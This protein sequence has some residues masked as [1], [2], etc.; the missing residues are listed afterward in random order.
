M[1]DVKM[2]RGI[3]TGILTETRVEVPVGG[4]KLGY[5]WVTKL[6]LMN[7]DKTCWLVSNWWDL[8]K[9]NTEAIPFLKDQG[10]KIIEEK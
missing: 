7:K 1:K 4:G 8:N 5:K 10:W 3:Q 6:T 9:G 2:K